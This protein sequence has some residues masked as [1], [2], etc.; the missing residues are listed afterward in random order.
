[1]RLDPKEEGDRY[2][3]KGRLFHATF[4][5]M[6]EYMRGACRLVPDD[7][8]GYNFWTPDAGFCI[9]EEGKF[10]CSARTARD[11]FWIVKSVASIIFLKGGSPDLM[12]HVC[13]DLRC[14]CL[15]PYP[16][17]TSHGSQVLL[18]REPGL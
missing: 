12:L 15:E 3:I 1:M 2:V 6:P 13:G 8:W 11:A 14:D 7:S 4:N 5:P 17:L 9:D 18:L 16:G 10:D